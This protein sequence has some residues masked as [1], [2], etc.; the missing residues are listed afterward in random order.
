MLTRDTSEQATV[1]LHELNH[2][3]GG[4][5]HY[6]EMILKEGTRVCKNRA[7]CSICNINNGRSTSC[8][9]YTTNVDLSDSDV[10]CDPCKEEILAHLDHHH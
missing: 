5:D 10:F 8:I 9:M 7:R 3:Y 4:N 2:Q 6:H 1:L